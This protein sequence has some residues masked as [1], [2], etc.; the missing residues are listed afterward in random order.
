MVLR[1]IN[2]H[3]KNLILAVFFAL[4]AGCSVIQS[5]DFDNIEYNDCIIV[6][7]L[8]ERAKPLCASGSQAD[9]YSAAVEIEHAAHH[10]ENY[11]SHRINNEHT[12]ELTRIV[13]ETTSELVERY[14]DQKA[15]SIYC[16]AKLDNIADEARLGAGAMQL[17]VR[18]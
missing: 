8:A 6:M 12:R 2:T 17:K 9:I 15:S 16:E 7:T 4:L 14:Q 5:S 11:A 3:M 13:H 1:I 10:L 18:R